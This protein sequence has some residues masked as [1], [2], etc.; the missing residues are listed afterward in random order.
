VIVW[1]TACREVDPPSH[2][3]VDEPQYSVLADGVPGGTLL[4]A[5]SSGSTVLAVGGSFGAVG[6][7]GVILRWPDEGEPCVEEAADATLWWIH[8]TSPDDWYA[9]GDRGTILHEQ[10][11]VRTDESVDTEATL[12]GVW[13]AD[14]GRVWAVGGNPRA[15]DRGEIWVRTDGTWERFAEDLDGTVFKVWDR[16]FV[17]NG[18]A[19]HLEDGELVDRSP[20][21]NLRLL[22]VRGRSDED[23]FAVGGSSVPVFVHWD[24]ASFEELPVDI[25]CTSQPLNGVWTGPGEDV[26]LAGNYGTMVRIA[27]DGTWSCPSPPVTL[28]HFHAVWPHEGEPWWFGGNLFSQGGNYGTIGREGALP[29]E[30]VGDCR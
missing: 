30:R 28:E 13:A 23:V 17:G 5:W 20:A 12:F 18:L 2:S 21:G 6:G 7:P 26:Y 24:G 14:D 22:T 19:L 15:T 1:L 16:W 27:D 11:G 25:N 29:P 3:G 10:A 8:G 9:V 4:G